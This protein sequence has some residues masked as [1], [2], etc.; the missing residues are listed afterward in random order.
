MTH[1]GGQAGATCAVGPQSVGQ[2]LARGALCFGGQTC[3]ATDVAV[4]LGKMSIPGCSVSPEGTICTRKYFC[5]LQ[6]RY[7]VLQ[8]VSNGDKGTLY[9]KCHA[10][11]SVHIL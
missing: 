9:R 6:H 5:V 8:S 4:A 2:H 1:V 3:T 7:A 11:Q 10:A